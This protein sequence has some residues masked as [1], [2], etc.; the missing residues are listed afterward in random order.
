MSKKRSKIVKQLE[1][2]EIKGFSEARIEHYLRLGYKPYLDEHSEIKW[3][4]DASRNMRDAKDHRP[5]MSSRI[6]TRNALR[7][8]HR[9]MHRGGIYGF[10]CAFWPF[11]V[12]LVVIAGALTLL[13]LYPQILI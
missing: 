13:L 3:L 9:K 4:T 2:H 11:I 12:T 8:Q 6:A 1:L 7:R 10:F 5:S